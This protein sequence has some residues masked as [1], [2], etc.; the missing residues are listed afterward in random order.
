MQWKGFNGKLIIATP[1]YDSRS[2][3]AYTQSMVSTAMFLA[4]AGVKW[5]FMPLNGFFDVGLAC[6]YAI[7]K[8]LQDDGNTHLLWIDYDHSWEPI[9][10]AKLLAADVDVICASYRMKNN[11]SEFTASLA[12]A[13]NGVLGKAREGEAPLLKAQAI[14]GGFTLTR[15]SVY[16]RYAKA[17]PQ[18]TY[19]T[20]AA[21][22]S[23][24]EIELVA[25]SSYANIDGIRCTP[26]RAFSA[27]LRELG[28]DMWV[29]PDVD[30]G[31]W[32]TK[33]WNG[34]LHRHLSGEDEEGQIT[35]AAAVMKEAFPDQLKAA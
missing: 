9:A 24:G 10:I 28:I 30:I 6:D 19:K 34:N 2:F 5:D 26:D 15:R 11:W 31:H 33:C 23:E 1:F 32:G 13:T 18:R 29:E 12:P 7:H 25:F 22:V 14:T 20:R 8:F 16:E 17:Y 3:S 27:S 35:K 21:G 4:A